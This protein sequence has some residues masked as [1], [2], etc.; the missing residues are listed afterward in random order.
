MN[1]FLTPIQFKAILIMA[2]FFTFNN[3]RAQM[4]Q[5]CNEMILTVDDFNTDLDFSNQP[6][7]C[8]CSNNNGGCTLVRVRMI[9]TINGIETPVTFSSIGFMP[10]NTNAEVG[11]ISKDYIDMY[12]PY[13]N[14]GEYQSQGTFNHSYRF[15]PVAPSGHEFHVLVC[16]GSEA[17]QMRG[18]FVGVTQGSTIAAPTNVQASDGDSGILVTFDSDPGMYYM[19]FRSTENCNESWTAIDPSNPWPQAT[20][21]TMTIDAQSAIPNEQFEYRVVASNTG[22]VLASDTE[23]AWSEPDLGHYGNNFTPFDIANSC[24][25]SGENCEIEVSITSDDCITAEIALLPNFLQ[26]KLGAGINSGENCD[27]TNLMVYVDQTDIFILPVTLDAPDFYCLGLQGSLSDGTDCGDVEVCYEIIPPGI[28]IQ[29]YLSTQPFVAS[30][31]SGTNVDFNPP[32]ILDCVQNVSI[33]STHVPGDFFPTGCTEV[34]HTITFPDGT[35]TDYVQTI[36]VTFQSSCNND[37][38]PPTCMNQTISLS[39]DINTGNAAINFADYFSDNCTED[40]IISGLNTTLGFDVDVI[41]FVPCGETYVYS[42]NAVDDAGNMANCEFTVSVDCGQVMC[43]NAVIHFDGVNDK[44][45]AASPLSG[46]SDYTISLDF[47]G[48]FQTNGTYPRLIGFDGFQTEIGVRGDELSYYD[49]NSWRNSGVEVDD[50]IWRNVTLV[51]Q[52]SMNILYVDGELISSIAAPAGLNF[53]GNISIGGKTSGSNEFFVGSIDNVKVWNVAL[54]SEQICGNVNTNSGSPN[55]LFFN[56]EEGVGG[57]N[58][59]SISGPMDLAGGNNNG[60]FVEFGLSGDVSNYVCEDYN[61]ACDFC[62][63]DVTPPVFDCTFNWPEIVLESDGTATLDLST[64]DLMVSDDCGEVTITPNTIE[65]NCNDI[66]SPGDPQV[67]QTVLAT[68]ES[69]N[70]SQ[71]QVP[72]IVVDPN[73]YCV[74][75]PCDNTALNFDGI[76]DRL[77]LPNTHTGDVEFTLDAWFFSNN[78]TLVNGGNQEHRLFTLGTSNRLEIGDLDGNIWMFNG[79][80]ITTTPNIRDGQWHHLAIVRSG[81]RVLLYLDCVLIKNVTDPTVDISSNIRVGYFSNTT[82]FPQFMWK[83]NVDEIRMWDYAQSID[84]IIRYKNCLVDPSTPGLVSHWRM[85]DGIGFANNTGVTNLVDEVTQAQGTIVDF[86]MLVD[87]SNFVCSPII[88]E[89][90]CIEDPCASDVVVPFCSTIPTLNLTLNFNGGTSITP[91]MIDNGSFDECSEVTFELDN[92]F[93]TC[94]DI[95][96]NIVTL[97]VTD[98]SGNQ[99]SC[100]TVVVIEDKLAPTCLAQDITVD[101]SASGQVSIS[102]A[103]IDGCSFDACGYTATLSQENFSCDDI[104]NVSV[105]LTVSDP[106]GNSSSCASMVTIN[107]PTGNCNPFCCDTQEVFNEALSSGYQI[108]RNECTVTIQ[109]PNLNSCYETIIDWGDGTS[110]NQAGTLQLSHNYSADGVYEVCITTRQFN[111]TG[112]ICNETS[113]CTNICVTCDQECQDEQLYNVS[114][115]TKANHYNFGTTRKPSDV[116]FDGNQ[117]YSSHVSE[118]S[119]GSFTL[120]FERDGIVIHTIE[121]DRYIQVSE[122]QTFDDE[123]YVTGSFNSP[124][125]LVTSQNINDNQVEL[126]CNCYNLNTCAADGY[127]MKFDLNFKL[128]WAFSFGDFWRDAIEDITIFGQDD[129][130]ITG[131][132]RLAVDFDPNDEAIT[133]S[134][135]VNHIKSFVARYVPSTTNGQILPNCS[136]VH[137]LYLDDREGSNSR[138]LGIDHDQN[139]NIY[140]VGIYEANFLTNSALTLHHE[141]GNFNAPVTEVDFTVSPGIKNGYIAKYENSGSLTWIKNIEAEGKIDVRGNDMKEMFGEDIIID[142]SY[143]YIGGRN[144]ISKWDQNGV[145]THEF[146]HDGLEINEI[147]FW[148]ENIAITGY[149]SDTYRS[150]SFFDPL[151]GPQIQEPLDML[152]SVY[153]KDFNYLKSLNPGGQSARYYGLSISSNDTQI[154]LNGYVLGSPGQ[155]FYPDFPNLDA[156]AATP[157]SLISDSDYFVGVYECGCVNFVDEMASSCC[158]NLSSQIKDDLDNEYCCSISINNNQ[159]ISISA[160]GIELLDADNSSF[161]VGELNLSD[162]FYFSNTSADYLEIS[163]DSESIPQGNLS[164]LLDFCLVDANASS[165]GPQSYVI[166]YI[167]NLDDQEFIS[168][169]DT[170][171]ADCAQATQTFCVGVSGINAVCLNDNVHEVTF[172]VTNASPISVLTQLELSGLSDGFSFGVCGSDPVSINTSYTDEM[173]SLVQG[174]STE[175]CVLIV[176]DRPINTNTQI[177]F[178]AFF[179]DGLGKEFC[180]ILDLSTVLEPCCLGCDDVQFTLN[181]IKPCCYSLDLAGICTGVFYEELTIT[182]TDEF[183]LVNV[184]VNDD[185]ADTKT[186][187][188]L[189]NFDK[190]SICLSPLTGLID[191]RPQLNIVTFCVAN[192]SNDVNE[193]TFSLAS[194]Q[195]DCEQ[196]IGL[197]CALDE[198]VTEGF[199]NP[200]LTGI[201]LEITNVKLE[202]DQPPLILQCPTFSEIWV[203]GKFDCSENCTST[204]ESEI[205]LNGVSLQKKTYDTDGTWEMYLS[206]V[207]K[208]NGLYEIVVSGMCGDEMSSCVYSF[209]ISQ[210]C[211]DCSCSDFEKDLSNLFSINNYDGCEIGISPNSLKSCDTINS[212]SFNGDLI[213]G[214]FFFEEEVFYDLPQKGDYEVCMSVTRIDMGGSTCTETICENYQLA[215]TTDGVNGLFCEDEVINNGSF[216]EGVQ[217]SMH[218][219]EK[220]NIPGWILTSGI[221]Y[222]FESGGSGDLSSGFVQLINEDNVT[223][224][225]GFVFPPPEMEDAFVTGPSNEVNIFHDVKVIDPSTTYSINLIIGTDTLIEERSVGHENIWESKMVSFQP[226]DDQILLMEQGELELFI[227]ACP[228]D[229]PMTENIS[230]VNVDNICIEFL[231][232]PVSVIETQASDISVYP[233]PTL[234]KVFISDVSSINILQIFDV[235]GRIVEEVN[236]NDLKEEEY[237]DLYG[238]SEGIYIM[239]I[240]FED[241]S[242]RYEKIIKI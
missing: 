107:D 161:N 46:N 74:I 67:Y 187:F 69:G 218:E 73:N 233:N 38:E 6:M 238:L 54:T 191:N 27:L 221:G 235:R 179:L 125:L 43:D 194:K 215:C 58:N 144:Y 45:T 70:S 210:D 209:T 162:G 37:T 121:S 30:N 102:S 49:G 25:A 31:P 91:S 52:A 158:S 171:I 24:F 230:L 95:G 114:N 228:C 109:S 76:N 100:T 86:D 22:F 170:L 90:E 10:P 77:N 185:P 126:N 36:H 111:N 153:D 177:S 34:V 21:N 213:T 56:F 112:E 155:L 5:N 150:L 12:N 207:T 129:F 83:G 134:N 147:T 120:Y 151:N 118:N 132:T 89:E 176:S 113:Y 18:R 143:L 3:L 156:T 81:D 135:E 242:L 186:P 55:A 106:S 50:N 104:G 219:N 97:F 115:Y 47:K 128:I 80:G 99:S 168:C 116:Y 157:T 167:E 224:K 75:E 152:F 133:E 124:S 23:G 241:E 101:L 41:D 44:I 206:D 8:G 237:V 65:V 174:E 42:M 64:L 105:I 239:K 11:H 140:A 204:I 203:K 142:D 63:P 40:L 87:T 178:D 216:D 205:F 130:A 148:N 71:C 13:L 198:C 53:S 15:S 189:C 117:L 60:T 229:V 28:F 92:D 4:W 85:E 160:I 94:A 93:F 227:S 159:G 196:T 181:E 165:S 131:V 240:G 163:H 108:N 35:T 20:G 103:Q 182:G 164:G 78:P 199:A 137:T 96:S 236:T 138:G 29:Q 19:A 139:G 122:I 9:E 146:Y 79:N 136:W 141:F 166:S 7:D 84:E 16:P 82:L 214:P 119:D 175:I 66:I 172:Q 231:K 197:D 232:T 234:N 48:G 51:R 39:G 169:T 123:I 72:I 211:F 223:P 217:G 2:L 127:V 154:A 184:E 1:T 145:P 192:N 180:S 188:E 59:S 33:S 62:N 202:C 98:A 14:C 208:L 68:D 220:S 57:E 149:V 190:T 201:G 195:E 88:F 61:I 183:D 222:Y 17:G 225:L 32:L 173:L 26:E 226:T 110:S 193:V 212:Y 200:T